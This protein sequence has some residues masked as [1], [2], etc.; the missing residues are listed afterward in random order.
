MKFLFV[1]SPVNNPKS[2][3][4]PLEFFCFIK[5]IPFLNS[6]VYILY[7][8]SSS[9]SIIELLFSPVVSIPKSSEFVENYQPG[10]DNNFPPIIKHSGIEKLLLDQYKNYRHS[11]S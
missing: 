6:S 5:I 8:T 4:L 10:V 7:S 9:K 1:F 11:F 2:K 3:V